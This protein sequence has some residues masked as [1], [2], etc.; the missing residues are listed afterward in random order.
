MKKG[1]AAMEFLITYGWAIVVV[2]VALGGLAYMNVLNPDNLV[3]SSCVLGPGFGCYNYKATGRTMELTVKNGMV[4]HMIPVKFRFSGDVSKC[5]LEFSQTVT[6]PNK[7]YG[8][9]IA[10]NE[11]SCVRLPGADGW[12]TADAICDDDGYCSI[13]VTQEVDGGKDIIHV[14]FRGCEEHDGS[15]LSGMQEIDIEVIYQFT[16]ENIQHTLDGKAVLKVEK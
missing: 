5:H 6:D 1:Q 16:D 7:E 3:P 2:L 11:A 14:V 4:D 12:E 10:T 13:D 15:P 9:C 8:Y